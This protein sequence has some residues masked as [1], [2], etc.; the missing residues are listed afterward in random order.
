MTA[1]SPQG[2]PVPNFDQALAYRPKDAS[3]ISGFSTA[4]IYIAIANGTL[5]SWK[6]GRKR[7][8]DPESLRKLVRGEA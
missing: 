4:E 2:R 3:T 1:A 5:K 8:I 7:L 6:V